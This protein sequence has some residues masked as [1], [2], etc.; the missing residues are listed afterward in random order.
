MIKKAVLFDLDNTLYEYAGPHKKALKEVHKVLNE[1]I[2]I[3]L[4]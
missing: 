3:K 2:K 1:Y 4:Y